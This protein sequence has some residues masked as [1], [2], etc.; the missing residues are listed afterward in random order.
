ML[1][2]TGPL[3]TTVGQV[4]Q[5]M[6]C[7]VWNGDKCHIEY[8]KPNI[9]MKNCSTYNVYYLEPTLCVTAYC[10]GKTWHIVWVYHYSIL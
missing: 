1:F 3:A 8:S 7:G 4:V 9:K 2:F 6:A 10:M 5:G